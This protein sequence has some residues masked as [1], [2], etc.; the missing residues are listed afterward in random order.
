[1][2]RS[3]HC[4]TTRFQYEPYALRQPSLTRA[5]TTGMYSAKVGAGL[6]GR[7]GGQPGPPGVRP[8]RSSS[9]MRR[10]HHGLPGGG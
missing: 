7:R 9:S 6:P 2:R 8:I 10:V 5:D 3:P 1:M 4:S